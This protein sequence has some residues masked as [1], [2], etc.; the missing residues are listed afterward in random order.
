MECPFPRTSPISHEIFQEKFYIKVP[1]PVKEVCFTMYLWVIFLLYFPRKKSLYLTDLRLRVGRW[2]GFGVVYVVLLDLERRDP[3]LQ[4]GNH[5]PTRCLNVHWEGRRA[6]S[7]T[8]EREG[9]GRGRA[10]EVGRDTGSSTGD[11]WQNGFEGNW[12]QR[13]T[14]T[15]YP[16]SSTSFLTGAIK[17][18]CVTRRVSW[19]LVPW[20]CCLHIKEY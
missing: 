5:K 17:K 20:S 8:D 6:R 14:L 19:Y 4:K 16:P 9:E 18:G 12:D 11:S 1:C 2:Q 7:S 13:S 3:R 10:E 15:G